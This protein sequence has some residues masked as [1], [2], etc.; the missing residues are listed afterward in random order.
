[1][2][3][4]FGVLFTAVLAFAIVPAV[5]SA[6]D[7]EDAAAKKAARLAEKQAQVE[8]FVSCVNGKGVDVPAIDVAAV[9]GERALAHRGRGRLGHARGFGRHGDEANRIARF[10]VRAGDLDRANEGVREAVTACRDELRA[11]LTEARQD[12]V[13]DVAT[14]LVGKGRAVETVDL[15]EKPRLASKRNYLGRSARVMLRAADLSLDDA[16][17]RADA[18]ACA[19]EV[20]EAATA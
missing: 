11:A 2:S 9:V 19:K 5:A 15:A 13:D 7:S 18:R 14:C 8:S 16:T 6:A 20:K 4:R 17:V 1:M 12:D 10:V 3:K